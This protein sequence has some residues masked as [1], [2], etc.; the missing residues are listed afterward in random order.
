MGL[1]KYEKLNSLLERLP[2]GVAAPSRW[3]ADQGYS[4]Q[5]VRKYVQGKVCWTINS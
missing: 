3:P 5:L 4:R 2:E 1:Q